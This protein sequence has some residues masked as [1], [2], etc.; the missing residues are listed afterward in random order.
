MQLYATAR[1]MQSQQQQMQQKKQQELIQQQ[2]AAFQEQAKQSIGVANFLQQ[3]LGAR[4][5]NT[6]TP[7]NPLYQ[8]AAVRPNPV[9]ARAY[10]PC[11]IACRQ[12][13]A[14]GCDPNCCRSDV[15]QETKG[16]SN[17]ILTAE[18]LPIPDNYNQ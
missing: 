8:S 14:A 16:K 10:P 4:L 15:N 5:I 7:S 3:G 1:A 12:R 11:N 6:V 9:A 13:C 17:A 18:I 2:R